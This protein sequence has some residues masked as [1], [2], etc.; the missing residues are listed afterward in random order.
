MNLIL[1]LIFFKIGSKRVIGGFDSFFWCLI[2]FP[3]GIYFVLKSRRLDDVL[4]AEKLAKEF[5][6]S[7][8]LKL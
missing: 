7:K 3:L 2:F 4:A 8:R 1:A 6:N 5:E